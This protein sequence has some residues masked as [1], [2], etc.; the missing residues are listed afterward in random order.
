MRGL[1]RR[2][3]GFTL[4]EA[5]AAFAILAFVMAGLLQGAGGAARNEAHA[6][7]LLRATRQGQSQ[8]AALG[9][10][11]P[12]APGET[13]GRYDDG[14]E[15]SLSTEQDRAAKSPL[16][17]DAT[18]GYRARLTIRRPNS[19]PGAADSLTLMALKLVT[20]KESPR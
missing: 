16:G 17:L 6:D 8:L 2:R 19:R 1:I 5:L 10:E 18:F 11:T 14:L 7:F 3:G 13:V 20:I 9:V 4:I 15:W 12:I